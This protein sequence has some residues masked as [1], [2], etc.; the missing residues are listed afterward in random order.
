MSG[1]VLITGG[2]GSVGRILVSRLRQDERAVR[3]FDLPSMN[4]AGLE[5]VDGIE[6]IKGDITNVDTVRRAIDGVDA[7]IHLAAILPPVSERNR[8]KTFAV[9]VDGTTHIVRA[10]E[11]LAPQAALVFSSSVSTYGDTG[12][13]PPPVRVS[14]AQRAIDVYAESKI[15]GEQVLRESQAT[16]VIL[17]IA[18][19]A[20][21]AFQEPPAVWPFMPD[22]RVE[23]VHR[24]DVVTAIYQATNV[25]AARG[26]TFNIA[27]GSTWQM[28]GRE[29]VGR[30]YDLL[31]VPPE[32]AT[33]RNSPGWVDWYDTQESQQLLRYQRTPYG[34][35]LAQIEAEIAQLM[36]D[37]ED[38]EKP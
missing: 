26:Q 19:I 15:V 14:H 8:A 32:E 1:P 10:L 4:Y 5:G 6:V 38:L 24:D 31:G 28:T 36:G 9:N 21:P 7:V 13:E 12:Q 3:V 25:A 27:G 37:V 20:V 17:R 29:Y 18:G 2:A 23:L 30:L 22:Q 35:F 34:T 16:W 11:S 33:F